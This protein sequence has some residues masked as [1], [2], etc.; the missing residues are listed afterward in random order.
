MA[1]TA[2]ES[3][4]RP[5]LCD[6]D[7]EAEYHGRRKRETTRAPQAWFLTY[8]SISFYILPYPYHT[9]PK[10][11]QYPNIPVTRYLGYIEIYTLHGCSGL[12]CFGEDIFRKVK[13]LEPL[14]GRYF[15]FISEPG[16]CAVQLFNLRHPKS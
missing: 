16:N 9:P 2:E 3:C 7:Y 8:P 12:T 13:R 6:N 14:T 4:M 5:F 11:Y 15:V 1:V 10:P